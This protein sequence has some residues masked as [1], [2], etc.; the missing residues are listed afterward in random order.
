MPQQLQAASGN[1][2]VNS[3]IETCSTMA[4]N[5]KKY[6]ARIVTSIPEDVNSWQG[7]KRLV[8]RVHQHVCGH[9]TY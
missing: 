3:R 8:N 1:M 6:P 5:S 9:A 7:V 4:V 2:T